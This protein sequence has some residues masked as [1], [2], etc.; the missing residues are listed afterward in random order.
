[1]KVYIPFNMIVDIDFG[2]IRL[3]EKLNKIPEYSVNKLKSFLLKRNEENPL[4]E[5]CKLR[6]IDENS[7][8]NYEII[9]SMSKYYEKI[10][11]LSTLTDMIAFVI[12]T[13][14]LGLSN[15]VEI[16]IGCNYESEMAYLKSL[17]SS[18]EYDI[19]MDLISNID[20]NDYDCIFTKFMDESYV[21]YITDVVMLE[22][23]R[24]YVADYNFNTLYD[25]ESK[26][27]IISPE[28]QI[29]LESDGN[30]LH[31]VSLY[32]KK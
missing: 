20:L 24:I 28:F 12:N 25:D 18:L 22:G 32:N 23:K 19:D 4:S 16:M 30:I 3:V 7:K 14:K 10:L 21:F 26:E 11:S 8:Y 29:P 13:Y 17:L 27:R 2:I 6:G 9:L 5:Y 31:L 1:M 15:E